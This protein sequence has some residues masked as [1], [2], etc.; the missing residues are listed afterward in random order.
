MTLT[1][2]ELLLDLFQAC[3]IEY[4]FCSPG[5]EW[6]PV[7]EGLAKRRGR[8]DNSLKYINCRDEAL[9]VSMA[10]GYAEVSGS[11]PA[12]LLHAGVGPLHGAMAMRNA[13][14]ARVPMM[15][16][17]GETCEHCGDAEVRPQGWHWLG[18]LSDIGGPAAQVKSYVKW[19]N[20]VRSGD[21]LADAVYRG[22]QIARSVPAGPVF[23]AVPTEVLLRAVAG[24]ARPYP[25]AIGTAPCVADL[26]DAAAQ[27]IQARQPVIIAEHAGKTP[28]AVEKLVELAETLGIPVFESSLPYASNFPKNSPLYMGTG[29][30]E[31]LRQADLVLVVSAATPWYPPAAGPPENARVIVL[32]EA[33]LQERLPYWGYRVNTA[34]TAHVAT[35]LAALVDIVRR[36]VGIEQAP[37]YRERRQYWRAR[38]DEMMA[39]LE[40][41]ALAGRGARPIAAR[42]FLHAAKQ[43]LPPDA[44]ILDETI[45]HTRAVHAYLAEPGRYIKSA[46]GGLG[47]GMG[48][49]LGVKLARPERPVVL[50]IGDGAFNYNPA[51]AALGLGQEYGLPVFIIIFNNGGYMAMKFGHRMLYPQGAA[52]SQDSFLGA[53]ITPAPDYVKIAEAFGAYGE[54]LEDPA[55]IEAALTRGL[56]QT[57]AGNTALLDV[58]LESAPPF[59]PPPRPMAS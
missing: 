6:A 35:A 39:Q 58:V 25:V 8:G 1:G 23:I 21:G 42:W 29:V 20:E 33:P 34:I 36:E 19:S 27:L 24:T 49:A 15:V 18:L 57:A 10:Q 22:C 14:V 12:V 54:K 3:G 40:R 26:E 2:G 52:V 44:I 51:L 56:A 7:W 48:E 32:D 28:G 17:G 5:T 47:V 55:D 16:F 37:A 11:L 4:I 30:Q 53:A 31:A 50:M 9:A 59:T 43:A 38:H 46:Y 41:E 45:L 13:G